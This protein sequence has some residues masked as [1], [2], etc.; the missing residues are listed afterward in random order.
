MWLPEAGFASAESAGAHSSEMR[1]VVLSLA[2]KAFLVL[3]A[4]LR[5][6]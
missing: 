4:T 3:V 1:R 2:T 6:Q 5:F